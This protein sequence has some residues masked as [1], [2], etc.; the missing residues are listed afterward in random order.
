MAY[1]L[2]VS[3]FVLAGLP[4]TLEQVRGSIVAVGTLTPVRH[5]NAKKP[6]AKFTGTGFV[7]G[8]GRQIITNHHV[9]PESLDWEKGEGLAIFT[10][11]GESANGR[12]AKVIRTDPEHDLA[13]LE[14]SGAALPV[15]ELDG[16]S[17]V[18]EGEEVAFTGFPLGMVLGLYPATNKSIV[19][20]ITPVVMPARTARNLTPQQIKRLKTPFEIYQL[21]AISYPG[22]SGSPLYNIETGKVVGVLNS[23]FVKDTKESLLSSPSGITYAIPVKYVHELLKT[24]K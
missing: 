3:P 14:I 10:G 18:R 7:V 22:F 21:D 12:T 1:L 15:M 20:A 5:P 13:L 24:R 16:L 23:V 17:S 2:I 11:R 9:I 19:S 6:Q 8:N 4:E